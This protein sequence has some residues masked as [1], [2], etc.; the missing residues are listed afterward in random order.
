MTTANLESEP[1]NK[2]DA[3]DLDACMRQLT[4]CVVNYN[5]QPY[6]PSCLDALLETCP[7]RREIIVVDNASEDGSAE[8]VAGS[9]PEVRLIRLSEN[10][11]PPV[12]RNAGYAASL[13]AYVLFVDNDIRVSEGCVQNLLLSILH[14]PAAAV[15]MPRVCYL[16]ETN[17]I[18]YD[19][20]GCH[21]AG[22]MILHNNNVPLIDAGNSERFVGS[23]V[24]ACILVDKQRLG[25][26]SPFDESFFFN[27]EDHDFGLRCSISGRKILSVPAA[28]CHHGT[29]T[30]GLSYR[31]RS[32]YP[33]RRVYFLIRNR[34]L[35]LLKNY[36][37]STLFVLSPILVLYEVVQ[38]A[39]VASKGWAG[40]WLK[41]ASWIVAHIPEILRKR[42]CVQQARQ[43]ND[44][45]IF[46]M[47]HLPFTDEISS[48]RVARGMVGLLDHAITGYWKL[49]RPARTHRACNHE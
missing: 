33:R 36:Q 37:L 34:W 12:A 11:G 2:P 41:S 7:V 14:N 21:P 44:M 27:Y 20:A 5:G 47:D 9:Y 49:I 45:C 17:T 23:V 35:I 26:V 39:G 18:Q 16:D 48:S 42:R 38:L 19:G 22:L 1:A 24:S 8:M 40:E 10:L 32:R 29:G 30:K 15:A 13:G 3:A 31:N 6:L 43:I 28:L 25:M 4:I 46:E